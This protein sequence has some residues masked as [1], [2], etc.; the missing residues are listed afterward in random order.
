[1]SA[2][3]VLISVEPT[4]TPRHGRFIA[5]LAVAL[6]L[7]GGFVTYLATAGPG[8]DEYSL[9]SAIAAAQQAESIEYEMT[10]SLGALGEIASDG[11][12]DASTQRMVMNLDMSGFGGPSMSMILDIESGL[13][14]LDT[15]GLSAADLGFESPTRWVSI[16]AAAAGGLGG[17]GGLGGTE[18]PLAMTDPL[19]HAESITD[20]GL[21]DFRGEQVRHYRVSIPF[22]ELLAS[23]P[24]LASQV[25]AL[26][27]T[28]DSLRVVDYEVLVTQDNEL[29]SMSAEFDLMGQTV[30]MEF[31]FLQYGNV[32]PIDLPDP[33]DVTPEDATFG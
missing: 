17:F 10:M 7:I 26:G 30:S 8:D 23:N 32:E 13:A 25:G 4:P 6:L 9:Q 33:A 24:G 27:D 29:R 15:A 21:E 19:S 18:S 16:D 1:M 3:S 14:Y 22:D 11:R 20:L 28:F 31:V 2:P 5:V 12:F